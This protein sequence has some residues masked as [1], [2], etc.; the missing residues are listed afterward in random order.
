MQSDLKGPY[1]S[2][3]AEGLQFVV[4]KQLFGPDVQTSS[5]GS[6]DYRPKDIMLKQEAAALLSQL[7][8]SIRQIENN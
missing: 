1:S 3:A 8:K 2:W 6:V 4:G 5:A 7:L